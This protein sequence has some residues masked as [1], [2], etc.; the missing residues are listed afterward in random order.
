M[1]WQESEI[2]DQG[3]T[4]IQML[5]HLAQGMMLSG[6]SLTCAALEQANG[7]CQGY[8]EQQGHHETQLVTGQA[9]QPCQLHLPAHDG[10]GV[11]PRSHEA[12]QS[13]QALCHIRER[14]GSL[15]R[16]APLSEHRWR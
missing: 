16:S 15:E 1:G 6:L 11:V 12:L 14:H 2:A 5:W 4:A 9:Q 7:S 10:N 3:L 8:A 13:R